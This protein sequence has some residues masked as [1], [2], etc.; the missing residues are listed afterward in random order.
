M[1]RLWD[2][3]PKR[4]PRSGPSAMPRALPLDEALPRLETLVVDGEEERAIDLLGRLDPDAS[5]DAEALLRLALICF[6]LDADALAERSLRRA[7]KR[8]PRE[9]R[10]HLLLGVAQRRLGWLEEAEARFR[11]ALTIEPT[12]SDAYANRALTL[13]DLARYDE[14]LAVA[15]EGRVHAP[16]D[17]DLLNMEGL[18]LL[19]L[20]R[21][22]DAIALFDR[23]V[24]IESD[25]PWARLNRAHARLAAGRFEE[26]WVDFEA[27]LDLRAEPVPS[28]ITGARLQSLAGL[29]GQSVLV[30]AEQG[31]GD[32]IHFARYAPLLAQEGA[33]VVLR[34]PRGLVAT[35][36]SLPGIEAVVAHDDAVPRCDAHV[37]LLSLPGLLDPRALRAGGLVPYLRA[38]AALVPEE[39]ARAPRDGRLR[40]GVAWAGNPAHRDDRD[41]SLPAEAMQDLARDPRFQV[42]SLQV[43]EDASALTT[44]GAIDLA[45]ALSDFSITAAAIDA[46]D[47]IVSAD[48]AIAHLAGALGRPVTVLLPFAAEWRWGCTGASTPWYPSARLIRQRRPRIWTD[49]VAGAIDELGR[50]HASGAPA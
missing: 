32:T 45:P 30:W 40:V 14:A 22:E 50:L 41:R 12:F 38:N 23:L 2:T 31:A 17:P 18:S 24:E 4:A 1:L 7:V 21:A 42:F 35:M 46:L 6:R 29:A 10:L 34:C 16:D 33:R 11:R 39:L 36:R 15:R 47:H 25:A 26:G 3:S 28:G 9:A 27:R 37:P 20:G 48:T 13:Q 43:G 44:A 19:A 8:A 5:D 49:A